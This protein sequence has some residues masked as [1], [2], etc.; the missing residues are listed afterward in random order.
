M[1]GAL[2][3][4]TQFERGYL[5]CAIP[6]ALLFLLIAPRG[7]DEERRGKAPWDGPWPP[8]DES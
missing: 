7:D 1:I 5:A 8:E 3:A 4:L 6:A 2:L